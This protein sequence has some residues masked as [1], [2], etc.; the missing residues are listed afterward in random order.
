[1][2]MHRCRVAVLLAVCTP[3]AGFT[4]GSVARHAVAPRA[5]ARMDE[6]SRKRAE[7]ALERAQQLV[8]RRLVFVGLDWFLECMTQFFDLPVQIVLGCLPQLCHY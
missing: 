6:E 4:M 1:M 2:G 8:P 5:S 3:A 7:D